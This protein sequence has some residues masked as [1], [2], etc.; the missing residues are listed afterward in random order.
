MDDSR[1]HSFVRVSVPEGYERF[2]LC[3]L[4][5]PWAAELLKHAG[6]QPGWSVLDVATGL[7][8]VAQLAA[9]AVGPGGRVVASDISEPMLALAAARPAS[10]GAAPIEFLPC[11]ASQIDAP[12]DSFDAVLCQHGLQFFA[13][14][15]A[16]VLEMRRVARPG[17]IAVTSTWAAERPLGL[18]APMG[19]TLAELGVAEPYP[20]AFDPDSYRLGASDLADLLRAAGWHD[21]R[22]QTVEL[23]ARWDSAEQAADTMTGTP[24]GPLVSALPA[25]VQEQVRTR[26]I[27]KLGGSK[28]GVTVRTAS[29]I[30]RGVK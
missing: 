20:R 17:G 21:V 14:T 16:A 1:S 12:D 18:F 27:T 11:P 9:T 24:F 8:P 15:Q 25:R 7:G 30:A 10:A 3:Q 22:V 23:D 29:N 19:Q 2:M 5:E 28:V 26:L 4:F 13:D 6:L